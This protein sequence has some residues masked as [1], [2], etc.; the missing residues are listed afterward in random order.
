M[1]VYTGQAVVS[2]QI[3]SIPPFLL[4]F[5]LF[6]LPDADLSCSLPVIGVLGPRVYS[7][8]ISLLLTN[9]IPLEEKVVFVFPFLLFSW[10]VGDREY[11]SGTTASRRFTS[12]LFL[13]G[14]RKACGWMV[15]VA[16]WHRLDLVV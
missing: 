9:K 13:G 12:G 6:D 14:M 5:G 15:F 2:N 10:G 7:S 11:P 8:L 1:S 16:A 4:L 3:N